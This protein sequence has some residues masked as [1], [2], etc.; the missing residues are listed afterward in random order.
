MIIRLIACLKNEPRITAGLNAF[1]GK[2]SRANPRYK[3]GA[4]RRRYRERLR[5]MGEEC[6]ICKGRLGPIHYDEP[7]DSAHPFSFVIDEIIPVSKW[8][9]YGYSSPEAVAQD[10]SNLQAAH[11]CCNQA[12]GNKIGFSINKVTTEDKLELD[13]EW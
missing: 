8:K 9:E 10:W 12:K 6:G 3:N 11:Y 4:L 2:M 13:G 5:A 1:R 7:S